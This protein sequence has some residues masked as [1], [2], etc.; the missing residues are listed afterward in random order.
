MN[1]T[2]L[3]KAVAKKT[4][5]SQNNTGKVVNAFI[6]VVTAN[7]KKGKKINLMGFGSFERIKRAA[8]VGRNPQTGKEIKIKASNVPKF[9]ASKNLKDT[10]KK[11]K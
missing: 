6:D 7:L 11:A 4:N 8:R 2:E 9:R 10:V 1:K 5:L 3:V